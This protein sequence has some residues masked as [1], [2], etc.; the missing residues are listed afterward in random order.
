MSLSGTLAVAMLTALTGVPAVPSADPVVHTESG[1]VR[2]QALHGYRSYQGIPYAAAP[3]GELRWKAP[4][5]ARPWQGVRDATKP[6]ARCAQNASPSSGTA[7]S[8][9]E[10]CLFLNVTAPTGRDLPVLVYVHGGGLTTGA[11]SDLSARRLAVEGHA[12]VVTL[13]YRLGVFGYFGAPGLAGS[14]TFGLQDQQ[15]ALRWVQRNIRAFGGDPRRTTLFGESGGG[16]S[17]CGQLVSPTARGLFSRVMIQTGTCSTANP[18]DALFPGAGAKV[19]SWQPV[20]T[21]E[22]SGAMVGAKLGCPAAAMDCLR[23]LPVATLL[24]DPAVASVYWS[25]AYQTATLPEHPAAAVAAGHYPRIPVLIGTTKD[26]GTLL[27]ALAGGPQ[28][29]AAYRALLERAFGERAG[30]VARAYPGVDPAATWAAVVGDRGYVCP[31]QETE[32]ALDRRVPTYAYE[33]A[34][35]QA[36]LIFN[37]RSAFPLGAYHASDVPYLWDDPKGSPAFDLSRPQQELSDTMIDYLARFAATGDPNG[38]TTPYWPR[39]S[40]P[41]VLAPGRV[42]PA[43]TSA[44]HHCDLWRRIG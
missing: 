8:A 39:G 42:G 15:A 26:E 44:E 1:S 38:F 14:G 40:T 32:R 16:D 25:P 4:Q 9:S 29:L 31:N 28:D 18:V 22:A 41:Q 2:G 27:V 24:S 36:P 7:G 12:V 23:K 17:V 34:D 35:E 43:D 5:P 20:R 19:A 13:N 30:E 33:F 10:D 37:V 3:V 21:V 6:G 11:G